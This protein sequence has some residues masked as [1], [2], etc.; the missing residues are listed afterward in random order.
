MGSCMVEKFKHYIELTQEEEDLIKSLEER[1]ESYKAG[2]IIRNRGESAQDL[3]ILKILS[4][5]VKYVK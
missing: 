1:Q 3:I 4:Y 2:D 5:F